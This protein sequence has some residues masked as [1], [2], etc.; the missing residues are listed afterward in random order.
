MLFVSHSTLGPSLD[1]NKRLLEGAKDASSSTTIADKYANAESYHPKWYHRSDGWSGTTYTEAVDFCASR[2]DDD[3]HTQL[4]PYKVYCPTGSNSHVPLV[5]WS[6][7]LSSVETLSRTPIS[8]EVNGWV[9]IDGG[10]RTCVQYTMSELN[11]TEEN[12][13][14]VGEED[15][16]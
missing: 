11:D 13:D 4:C 9:Q 6:L 15:S 8:N 2:Q 7:S 3:L 12:D 16:S 5:M 10:K 14:M 1:P